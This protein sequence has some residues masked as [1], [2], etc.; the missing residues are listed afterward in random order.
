MQAM[1]NDIETDPS[2]KK[3]YGAIG[4]ISPIQSTFYH[5]IDLSFLFEIQ[6]QE[7]QK[8]VLQLLNPRLRLTKTTTLT[9]P[10]LSSHHSHRHLRLL[11]HPLIQMP[12]E[13]WIPRMSQNQRSALGKQ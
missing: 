13:S 12:S 10:K 7:N 11:K 3:R 5:C 1:Q 2:L 9:L 8:K 4:K 6:K